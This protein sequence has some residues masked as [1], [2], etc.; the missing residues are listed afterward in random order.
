MVALLPVRVE[1]LFPPPDPL[2]G[3]Y[4]ERLEVV[5]VR[6]LSLT[7]PVVVEHV[8]VGDQGRGPK[9]SERGGVRSEATSG[10]LLV[11]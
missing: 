7:G 6:P 5:V 8:G 10:R 9:R 2:E 11:M 1:D 4:G 3:G